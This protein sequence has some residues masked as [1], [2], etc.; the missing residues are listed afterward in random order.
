MSRLLLS[1]CFVLVFACHKDNNGRT[2][3]GKW[4]SVETY[5]DAPGG[6]S[7]WTIVLP[8]AEH[9]IEFK[10]NGKFSFTPSPVSAMAAWSG[11]YF[12]ASDSTLS[13]TWIGQQQTDRFYFDNTFLIIERGVTGG[14][15]KTR[16]RRTPF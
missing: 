14:V 2:L 4:V 1:F 6:C 13:W 15:S 5:S 16:Y 9:S 12:K 11:D 7:C 3:V 10:F 8:Y